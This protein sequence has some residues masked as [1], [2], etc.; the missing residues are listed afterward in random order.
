[1]PS[2]LRLLAKNRALLNPLRHTNRETSGRALTG[3][4]EPQPVP[5]HV[6]QYHYVF[7]YKPEALGA[8]HV[9][10]MKRDQFVLEHF[11]ML[12]NF[13]FRSNPQPKLIN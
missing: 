3:D 6:Y 7:D 11:F 1:M 8:F 2:L 13:D 12:E 9:Y 5:K 4:T 10:A